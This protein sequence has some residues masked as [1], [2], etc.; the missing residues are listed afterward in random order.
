MAGSL[1]LSLSMRVLVN[2]E[3]LNMS[4]SVGNVTKH[5]KA[6]VVIRAKEGGYRLIYVP[7][8]SGMSLAHGLQ[9]LLAQHADSM[10]LNVTRMS[11]N[12]FFM[13]FADDKIIQSYYPEVAD[14]VKGKGRS[15]CDVERTIVEKCVVADVG[16]FLYANK[17]VKRNSRFS[18]SYMM[19]ALDAIT[20][21]AVGVYPQQHVRYSPK[22][23][24]AGQ[25]LY[26][27]DTGSALY[28]LSFV[29]E[30]NKISRM[31]SCIEPK[32]EDKADLGQDERRRRFEA[33][34]RALVDMLD[35]IGFGAKKSRSLPHWV[36]ESAVVVA[37]Q[38]V[39]PFITTP[40]H[41][42]GYIRDTLD[43]LR[44]YSGDS[45]TLVYHV[46]EAASGL[47]K[48]PEAGEGVSEARNLGE[49]IRRAANWIAERL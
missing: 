39:A 10:G 29:L 28:T 3:S 44:N 16:G 5:R 22:P 46:S 13:K 6:P 27:V 41:S 19:P 21:G 18:F 38:G 42:S 25:M 24:E 40:G 45:W 33:T 17:P 11:L 34:V 2:L 36:V 7:V 8:V 32:E 9:R 47:T 37:Y 1:S 23:E 14:E 20:D 35:K 4:E 12:G 26:N 43:R 31:D 48:P 30:V 15:F 49:A